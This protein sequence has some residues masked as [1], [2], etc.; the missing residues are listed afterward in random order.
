ME[1]N[2]AS[3][4]KFWTARKKLLPVIPTAVTATLRLA[5]SRALPAKRFRA[6]SSTPPSTRS[7]ILPSILSIALSVALP[8]AIP[9]SS[10][11]VAGVLSSGM[12]A[13]LAEESSDPNFYWQLSN[14]DMSSKNYQKAIEHSNK[15]IELLPTF[16][17][18]YVNRGGSYLMLGDKDK[19]MADFNKSI[20]LGTASNDP[21]LANCYFNRGTL[22]CG[23][24]DYAKAVAD[25][26]EATNLDP[27]NAD[28]F[29]NCSISYRNMGQFQKAYD[30][31]TKAIKVEPKNVDA[32]CDRSKASFNLA[33][34]DET[35]KDANRALQINPDSADAL[36]MCSA[37]YLNLRDFE[38]AAANGERATSINSQLGEAYYYAGAAQMQMG[39]Y[40]KA[41][42]NFSKATE[43]DKTHKR[44]AYYERGLAY[45]QLGK[46]DLSAVDIKQAKELGWS[47]HDQM[48]GTGF[49]VDSSGYTRMNSDPDEA[50][51]P[52]DVNEQL[53]HL[54]E[55]IAKNSKD[56]QLYFSRGWNYSGQ[57]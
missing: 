47:I 11:V 32:Y 1:S 57:T 14:V 34:Y 12:Q 49:S 24:G 25:L 13:A 3:A 48:F 28:A 55:A 50:K 35:L 21:Y 17:G 30:E 33:R 36:M 5:R 39:Q 18:A 26:N 37:A 51:H 4:C 41:I 6:L 16:T 38:H 52:T 54:N 29:V 7:Q 23:L 45:A 56:G 8:A 10:L 27:K 40:E 31:C 20:E 46:K 19:A 22:Y 42:R 44:F 43:L 9:A 2:D 15:A 53:E